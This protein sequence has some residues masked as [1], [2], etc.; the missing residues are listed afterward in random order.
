MKK[1]RSLFYVTFRISLFVLFV[2]GFLIRGYL[3]HLR[4]K[5]PAQRL[6]HFS[7]LEFWIN[8]LCCRHFGLN[9]TVTNAPPPGAPGLIVGNHL[10]F[11]D[12]L[13]IGG[14][15]P[16]LFVTSQEMRETPVLGLLTEMAGCLYVERRNRLGIQG[17]LKNIIEALKAGLNVCLY[18]EATSHN[19]EK[20]L[21]FKRTLISAAAHAGVPI[22]PYV[23]NFRSIDGEPFNLKYR[24][25]V[26]WYGDMPFFTSM[27]AAFSLK[28]VDVE[29]KFLEPYH[30]TVDMDRAVVADELHARIAAHFIPVSPA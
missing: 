13:A 20:V 14:S 30:T 2:I 19:G 5:D 22:Y 16:M 15:R 3:I 6:R 10:G 29:I 23:F 25:H 11:L 7:Q 1:V 21:P 12:I 28:K 27:V 18:P 24:D 17:E 8:R 26:C 9:V 4:V